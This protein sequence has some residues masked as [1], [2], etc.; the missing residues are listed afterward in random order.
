[1][2]NK[3]ILFAL[4]DN[5]IL[6]V[7][8]TFHLLDW[9]ITNNKSLIIDSIPNLQKFKTNL[10]EIHI[11][12]LLNKTVAIKICES[13]E[14]LHSIMHNESNSLLGILSLIWMEVDN[15]IGTSIQSIQ[16]IN[17]GNVI[18]NRRDNF[19]NNST[20]NYSLFHFKKEF[21]DKINNAQLLEKYKI[22]LFLHNNDEENIEKLAYK[23]NLE[24]HFP[25]FTRIQRAFILLNIARTNYFL[26]MKI[27]F[28]INVLECLLLDV[29]AE[30]SLRLRL[31]TSI[32][33]GKNKEEKLDIMSIVN[34]AY[35]VR[36]KFFHGSTI[37]LT[38]EKLELLSFQLDDVTRRVLI[39]SLNINEIIN[40][41]DNNK[42]NDYFKSIMFT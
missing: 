25:N 12:E 40:A 23:S 16:S 28:Y 22:L 37:P 5:L 6:D 36:S 39:K 15:S 33:L 18:S 3:H 35:T 34:K 8:T 9:T 24:N 41:K 19:V 27:A 17:N 4:I 2:E 7:N 14:N 29:D 38:Q 30:L 42:R 13:N 10:G 26:P 32:L 31:Y 20:G 1:M 11:N 21:I